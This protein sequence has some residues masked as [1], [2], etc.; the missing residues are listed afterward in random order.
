MPGKKIEAGAQF[1]QTQAVYDPKLFETFIR[2]TEGFG[3]PIQYGIV[4][5]KSGGMATYMNRNVYGNLWDL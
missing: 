3:V 5:I 2:K 1:F 4:V